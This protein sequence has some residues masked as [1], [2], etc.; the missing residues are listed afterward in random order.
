MNISNNEQNSTAKNK[1]NI[2]R[3]DVKQ[4]AILQKE[5]IKLYEELMPYSCCKL[6]KFYE[7]G[8]QLCAGRLSGKWK[9]FIHSGIKN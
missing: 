6:C 1:Y 4:I 5:I 7:F 3:E 2:S 8:K 9:S